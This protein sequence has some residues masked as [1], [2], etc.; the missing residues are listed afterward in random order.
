MQISRSNSI[1]LCPKSMLICFSPL[2]LCLFF[3]PPSL[4]VSQAAQCKESACPSRRHRRCGFDPW[5]GKIPWRRKWQPTPV[6]FL[7]GK[8]RGQ[9]RLMGYSPRVQTE[10]LNTHTLPLCF[11]AFSPQVFFKYLVLL[12][13]STGGS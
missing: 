4:F 2:S 3:L 5:V 7:P 13:S 6:F 11:P 1:K 10:Q 8:S 12:H 9:R